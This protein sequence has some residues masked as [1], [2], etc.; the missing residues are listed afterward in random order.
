MLFY[1]GFALDQRLHF[2]IHTR[3]AISKGK[4]VLG[5]LYRN[6]GRLGLRSAFQSLI[7]AKILPIFLHGIAVAAPAGLGPLTELEKLNRFAARLVLNDYQSSYL[8]LLCELN[9][10]SVGRICY[11]RRSLLAY[12]YMYLHRHL[13]SDFVRVSVTVGH[14]STR[15][16]RQR[17][18]DLQFQF[19]P[20][21]W[22]GSDLFPIF[23]MFRI[24]NSLPSEVVLSQ[25]VREAKLL[26]HSPIIYSIL[27]H[28]L[29]DVIVSFDSL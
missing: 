2:D 27:Q 29:P 7:A 24:W 10:K 12:K 26:I 28:R 19:G 20:F 1:L 23:N 4:R 6:F 3:N 15:I 25:S 18:H 22:R 14:H 13:P 9:W 8:Q 21:S 5:A 11:E 17:Q 16:L